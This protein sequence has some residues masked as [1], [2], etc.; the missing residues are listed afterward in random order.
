MVG[1]LSKVC[2]NPK[3]YWMQMR[4]ILAVSIIIKLLD[5]FINQYVTRKHKHKQ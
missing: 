4:N 5:E 1:N 3:H 2:L